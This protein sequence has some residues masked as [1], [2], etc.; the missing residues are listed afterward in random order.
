MLCNKPA[1]ENTDSAG[2]MQNTEE[3][4]ENVCKH[5][6]RLLLYLWKEERK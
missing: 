1:A 4:G 5:T 3:K 6:M 2:E